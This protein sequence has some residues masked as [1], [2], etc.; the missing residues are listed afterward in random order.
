MPCTFV[1]LPLFFI[2]GAKKED[3]LDFC[4]SSIIG[5]VWGIVFIFG[6]GHLINKGIN[7]PISNAIIIFLITAF[8]VNI[9]LYL[10]QRGY[11]HECQ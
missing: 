8:F 11:L 6:I 4:S 10:Q 7:E 1:A 2:A 5:V 3:I 9:T